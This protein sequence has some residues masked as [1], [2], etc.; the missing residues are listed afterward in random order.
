MNKYLTLVLVIA[1]ITST[2]AEDVEAAHEDHFILFLEEVLTDCET[3]LSDFRDDLVDD[4]TPYFPDDI[5]NLTKSKLK[6]I[7]KAVKSHS[8]DEA[9]SL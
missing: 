4:S 2:V 1:S 8:K 6:N 3:F 9:K 5:D 7:I